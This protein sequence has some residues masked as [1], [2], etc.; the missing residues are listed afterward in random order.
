MRSPNSWTDSG[1]LI[2]LKDESDPQHP[3]DA[4][5]FHDKRVFCKEPD[6][7]PPPP[8]RSSLATTGVPVTSTT[9]ESARGLS[10][11]EVLRIVKGYIGVEGGYLGDFSYASHSDF[12]AEYVI[13]T[14]I[15]S[16]T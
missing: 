13:S 1:R 9:P 10:R 12:Y 3:S 5:R 14:S 4:T 11:G 8:G 6:H 15:P 16:T 7:P 2:V